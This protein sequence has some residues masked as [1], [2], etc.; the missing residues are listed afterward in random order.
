MPLV[1]NESPRT[2]N[3]LLTVVVTVVALFA[4]PSVSSAADVWTV[5]AY[6]SG[7]VLRQIFEGM[8][9]FVDD[10]GYRRMVFVLVLMMMI[11][12]LVKGFI[13]NR[14]SP[15]PFVGMILAA[16]VLNIALYSNSARTD[17]HIEDQVHGEDYL[18]EDVP[19]VLAGASALTS[20]MSRYM[21]KL[22][23]AFYMGPSIPSELMMSNNNT[24]NFTNKIIE[25]LQSI[26][27]SEPTTKATFNSYVRECVIPEMYQGRIR[28]DRLMNSKPEDFWASIRVNNL[29]RMSVCFQACPSNGDGEEDNPCAATEQECPPAFAGGT[30]VTAREW[31]SGMMVTCEAG[32]AALETRITKLI[33]AS[34]FNKLGNTMLR[35][36]T[37]LDG[38]IS[39]SVAQITGLGGSTGTEHFVRAGMMNM[40]R[41]SSAMAIANGGGE[42]L[43]SVIGSEQAK[44]VQRT[45]W[46]V[47][48]EVFAESVSYLW[49]ALQAFIYAIFPIAIV[50]FFFPAVGIRA[51]GS[52]F[53]LLAWISLWMPF[54][55]I[56]NFLSLGW[57][58]EDVRQLAMVPLSYASLVPISE[59][60][61][62]MQA[63]TNFLGTMVPVLTYGMVKGGEFALTQIAG[64][65]S[66]PRSSESA[67][68]NIANKSY[69]Y[70]SIAANNFGANK[71]DG[72]TTTTTGYDTVT[73]K[74]GAGALTALKPESFAARTK[75]G[76][77]QT[78]AETVAESG[79]LAESGMQ[80]ATAS[81]SI[82]ADM[83]SATQVANL[84]KQA[85][86][87]GE[88]TTAQRSALL[89]DSESITNA[90]DTGW[91]QSLSNGLSVS[92]SASSSASF[93]GTGQAT[94]SGVATMGA[95]L[96]LIGAA[97]GGK[98]FQSG[99]GAAA[100]DFLKSRYGQ[101]DGVMEGINASLASN[102]SQFRFSSEQE[103]E[104]Y[105]NNVA[106]TAAA[107]RQKTGASNADV[108]AMMQA[109][110]LAPL[111]STA[112]G[113][114]DLDSLQQKGGL[115][116][117]G[118]QFLKDHW[119][120]LA[121]GAAMLIPGVG[122]AAGGARVGLMAYRAFRAGEALSAGAKIAG[123]ASAGGAVGAAM[124]AD[125]GGG[126]KRSGGINWFDADG[127]QSVT[128]RLESTVKGESGT[129]S[130][131]ST[132]SGSKFG[133]SLSQ[134]RFYD[135]AS[136]VVNAATNSIAAV[137][138]STNGSTS[139]TSFK[140]GADG[141]MTW[142]Y[143]RQATSDV[144]GTRTRTVVHG[145]IDGEFMFAGS[146][147]HDSTEQQ[148]R[149]ARAQLG[150]FK[151]DAENRAENPRQGLAELAAR[152]PT[153]TTSMPSLPALPGGASS[154]TTRAVEGQPLSAPSPSAVPDASIAG[155][156]MGIGNRQAAQET[157]NAV[158]TISGFASTNA[159]AIKALDDAA[160]NVRRTTGMSVLSPVPIG[161]RD[162]IDAARIAGEGVRTAVAAVQP[163]NE[164]LRQTYPGLSAVAAYA[165]GSVVLQ[166]RD[167]PSGAK[168]SVSASERGGHYAIEGA[169]SGLGAFLRGPNAGYL[170]D[171]PDEYRNLEDRAAVA[172]YHSEHPESRSLSNLGQ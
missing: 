163:L 49:S 84:A 150:T 90:L 139:G 167:Q 112:E 105:V 56:I 21:V 76:S 127:S 41:D 72:T 142:G 34:A 113:R 101:D 17:I 3:G 125:G 37:I 152:A 95:T 153:P 63:I 1:P 99:S 68:S 77:P 4:I 43:I 118:K 50:L 54:L 119:Q 117:Q 122:L 104:A 165:N 48:A 28:I 91:Q 106:D 88:T 136:G 124:T 32:H 128:G 53:G 22:V 155:A 2:A 131:I 78:I 80:G 5:Y 61:A 107:V 71:F 160:T 87:S 81:Q 51:M 57:L 66:A 20:E 100:I 42:G 98:A 120:D 149:T 157:G 40:F 156:S 96:G 45:N 121:L 109:S 64:E 10:P 126:A 162:G 70:G 102:G 33:G 93:S 59:A 154:A 138:E 97:T 16:F 134:A 137:L 161:T 30:G 83:T 94:I 23:E 74:E 55:A 171:K 13:F 172:K 39:S 159:D 6:G 144:S 35:D 164:T 140:L 130:G 36:T 135:E 44:A 110:G 116:E 18:V 46:M 170:V 133:M 103:A 19:L 15:M 12:V 67:A 24:F 52:Y 31:R 92:S 115:T 148:I 111:A 79:K 38:V 86:S 85:A 147:V 65:A 151:T 168:F 73:S 27:L 145:D 14:P 60:G 166:M 58:A 114:A 82:S 108:A 123:A 8:K 141:S 158:R 25:G 62:N 129:S 29:A 75:A 143:Q 146:A 9:G 11:F 89:R 132:G 47:A 69:S 26:S 7:N 169:S